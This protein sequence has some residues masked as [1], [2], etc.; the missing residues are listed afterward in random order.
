MLSNSSAQGGAGVISS[1]FIEEPTISKRTSDLLLTIVL[2][3]LQAVISLL[4]IVVSALNGFISDSC[5]NRGCNYG[6][7][8]FSGYLIVIASPIAMIL[9]LGFAI[10]L[11]RRSRRT[12]WVPLT[13]IGLIVALF[14]VSWILLAIG[15]HHSIGDFFGP[16]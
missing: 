10:W 13:G 5:T 7:I 12:W 9:A 14:F 1:V 15:S 2:F 8:T 16:N 6:L 4:A 11:R 3:L